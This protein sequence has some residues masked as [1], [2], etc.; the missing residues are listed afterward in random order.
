MIST[1][2]WKFTDGWLSA[3]HRVR[4]PN[5][6]DRPNGMIPELIVLHGISLPPGK[7][8]GPGIE[9]LFTN[10]LNPEDHPYYIHIAHI[11]VSAHFLIRRQGELLQFV[12]TKDRAW[13]AGQSCWGQRTN[14]NDFSIGVE[15]EGCDTEPYTENQYITLAA[16]VSVLQ[17]QYPQI[18]HDAIV[19]HSEIAPGRKTDPGPSFDWKKL[20]W[21]VK[22][23]RGEAQ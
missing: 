7:Y 10:S 23:C 5:Y 3:G 16:L 22:S 9:E 14:C 6:D 1:D 21:R 19:G 18:R 15:L 12:S 20:K 11:R 17:N 8:G 2:D 13:H 4:S